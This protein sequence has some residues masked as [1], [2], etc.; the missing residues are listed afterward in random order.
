MVWERLKEPSTYAGLAGVALALGVSEA[1]YGA[2]SAA[3]AA[4]AG[5]VAIVLKE[6]GQ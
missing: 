5:V 3:I 1:L 2:L 6:R 4:L